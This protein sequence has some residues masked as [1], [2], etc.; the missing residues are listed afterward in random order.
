MLHLENILSKKCSVAI[1]IQ[2]TSTLSHSF[3]FFKSKLLVLSLVVEIHFPDPWVAGF[4]PLTRFC[5][6]DEN[7]RTWNSVLKRKVMY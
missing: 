3:N 1:K 5:F 4:Y 7:D 2:L 6:Q